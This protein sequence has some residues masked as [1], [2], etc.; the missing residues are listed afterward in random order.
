MS[1]ANLDDLIIPDNEPQGGKSKSI[2]ALLALIV[3]L[4]IVG[5]VLAKM[6]FS[7]PDSDSNSTSTVAK[8]DTQLEQ[9]ATVSD[10]FKAE[11]GNENS[12]KDKNSADSL[13]DG[14][15]RIKDDMSMPKD[16]DTISAEDANKKSL[17]SSN[18]K[19][20]AKDSLAD[21]QLDMD[22]DEP[23]DL[24]D[25]QESESAAVSQPVKNSQPKT[26]NEH[27]SKPKV[28][29]KIQHAVRTPIGGSGNV[30][31]QVG[32]F[33]KGPTESFIDKIR[34]AGF[35]YRIKTANGY[36]RV[37]VGPFRSRAEAKKYLGRVR[38]KI[39]PNAFIK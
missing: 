39:A 2:I 22:L 15:A 1:E 38:A 36:R 23:K 31:I 3:L 37:F 30:Y 26:K 32:S 28:H 10:N 29:K 25:E 7:T 14:L 19:D 18:K 35:K 12:Q 27:K 4:L 20:A 21:N 33:T 5:A 16:V 24:K 11:A 17:K 6:I 34:R 13:D 8:E 9:K